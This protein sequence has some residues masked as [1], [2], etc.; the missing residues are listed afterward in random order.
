MA[1]ADIESRV[2]ALRA[3]LEHHN[4]RYHVLDAPE[5]SDGEYDR[6]Y[7]ELQQLEE[8]YPELKHEHSPTEKV[9]ADA[10]VLTSRAMVTH[11]RPM[12]SLENVDSEAA[13]SEW[14]ER[15]TRALADTGWP[16][17]GALPLSVEYKMDGVAIELVYER[18]VLVTGSTRGDGATGED[19]TQNLRTIRSL[20]ARLSDA[21]PTL[22]ELRAEVYMP[23]EAFRQLNFERSAELGLFANPRNATAGAIK[24]LDP[25]DA[26][27]RPL[28]I[29]IHGVG[30]IDGAPRGMTQADLFRRL[31]D[32]GLPAPPFVRS[33]EGLAAVLA[34]YREVDARRDELPFEIDGLVVKIDQL[35][36]RERLGQ[37][38]RSPRWA[39]A[40]KFAPRQATT[41]L[42]AIENQVGRTGALTPVAHLEPVTIGGVVVRRATLHN[43]REI[44]RK[45]I[46]IGD[47]VIVQ[48]AGDVIPEVVAAVESIRTG[49]ETPYQTPTAC[50]SCGGAIR[51]AEDEIVPYCDNILC[52]AQVRAR[53]EHFASRG[54]LDIEGLG[55]KLIDQLVTQGLVRTPADLYQLERESLLKLERMGQKS[56]EKLLKNLEVSKSRSLARLL[57]GLG[58]RNVGAHLA[59]VLAE[60]FASVAKLKS[61]SRSELESI[62]QVGPTIARSV[63]E[64]FSHPE[65]CAELD[66]LAAAGV[67]MEDSSAARARAPGAA[68]GLS[69]KRLVLTGT[70]A[71]WSRDEAKAKITAAGGRVTGSV[72]K[73]TDY[74]VAGADPG[75]KLEQAEKLGVPIIDEA[76]LLALLEPT[77]ASDPTS[78]TKSEEP[79]GSA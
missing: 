77:P 11:R 58:I 56:G 49:S 46:R 25:R 19:V 12:L 35:D 29:V 21:P 75:S 51:F 31:A 44:E 76:Q 67:R 10:F 24:Q 8:Q 68:T 27:A 45:G 36:A 43:P 32:W 52:P 13:F 55:E 4:F 30:V 63:A 14:L 69:G 66:R 23:T 74:V 2:R 9:G 33:V 61:A 1:S 60:Q 64:Y 34:I 42:V 18:G 79:H 5:I 38:S 59:E 72:A 65:N 41:R 28:E 50:P 20:P 78:A 26:V 47:R 57:H 16:S 7:R 54:A 73:S 71:S 37:R 3:E 62:D 39:V 22:L 70:L 17:G 40:F 15:T 53:L 48:R 6:L